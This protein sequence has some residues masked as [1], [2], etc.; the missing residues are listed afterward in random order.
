MARFH[1]TRLNTVRRCLALPGECTEIHF[2][3]F[4]NLR[5]AEME[6]NKIPPE[7]QLFQ[8]LYRG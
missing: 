6:Y 4:K 2:G 5:A 7:N 3:D 1:I 8:K